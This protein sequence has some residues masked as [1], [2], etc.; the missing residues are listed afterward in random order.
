MRQHE[1]L[2]QGLTGVLVVF[3]DSVL[4]AVCYDSFK[5][6][7]VPFR[8]CV[9]TISLLFFLSLSVSLDLVASKSSFRIKLSPV[10]KIERIS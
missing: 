1:C 5:C 3:L 2:R 10:L 7:R 8:I 4:F 6:V 9:L